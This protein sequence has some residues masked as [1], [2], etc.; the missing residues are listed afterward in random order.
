[1]KRLIPLFL[2]A[3]LP[4][5]AAT[6]IPGI[7]AFTT[8]A[9]HQIAAGNANQIISPFNIATALSMALAGAQGKTAAEIATVL[10]QQYDP[11]YHADL[12]ALLA[13]LTKAGNVGPNKLLAANALWVQSDFPIKPAFQKTIAGAYQGKLTPLDFIANPQGAADEINRWTAQH[14]EDKIKELFS[15]DSFNSKTRLVLTSAIYFYGKWQ[16]PFV[17]SRTTSD[18]FTLQSG[19]TTQAAF[20]KQTTHFNYAE[21]PAAQILEMPYQQT[22]IVFDVLLPKTSNGL[23][24]LEKSITS[25]SLAASLGALASRNVAVSLPKFHFD[26]KVK[27]AQALSAMGMPTAFTSEADFSGISAR[28]LAISQV[29]HSAYVDMSEQGTEAAAATGVVVSRAMA[30]MPQPVVVFRADHPFLFL[31]RDSR[32][33]VILF[34]GR[35]TNPKS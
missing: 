34:I 21:T 3:L 25:D 35:L 13:D 12:A 2:S 19:A 30:A 22:G 20:M 28:K 9:Y 8:A 23:P 15:P 31:I 10:R 32:S 11:S 27:L 18:S 26:F 7:N 16:E 1:L 29:V 4:A 5:T 24:D 14:T 17:P 6:I 33:G